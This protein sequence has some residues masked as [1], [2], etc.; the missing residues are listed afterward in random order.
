MVW[1]FFLW[2]WKGLVILERIWK[3]LEG[4]LGIWKGFF[5]CGRGWR[6]LVNAG[7]GN[8]REKGASMSLFRNYWLPCHKV[9][10]M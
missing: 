6:G 3:D 7:M 1:V 9:N 10:G 8:L 5:A 4:F 2:M